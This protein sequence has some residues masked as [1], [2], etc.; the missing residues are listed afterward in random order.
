[1]NNSKQNFYCLFIKNNKD[2]N[3]SKELPMFETL[4]KDKAYRDADRVSQ[5]LDKDEYVAVAEYR[6]SHQIVKT[7]AVKQSSCT[8]EI[9]QVEGQNEALEPISPYTVLFDPVNDPESPS[10]PFLTIGDIVTIRHPHMEPFTLAVHAI[11]HLSND[12]VNSITFE[13]KGYNKDKI[14]KNFQGQDVYIFG[15]LGNQAR[16]SITCDPKV[17]YKM[18][19]LKSQFVEPVK[20]NGIEKY[21]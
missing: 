18:L 9:I 11:N 13:N 2:Q 3:Y 4:D 8:I 15:A 7:T 19:T 20:I 17:V 6:I 12:R 16:P 10:R 5:G 1:M 21:L 14:G